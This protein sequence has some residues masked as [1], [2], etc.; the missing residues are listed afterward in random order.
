M[1]TTILSIEHSRRW[2]WSLTLDKISER[3]LQYK[4]IR[5]LWQPGRM[6]EPDLVD[7]F[8]LTM[9][10]NLDGIKC[11]KNKRKVVGRMGGF[12][13]NKDNPSYR[14]DAELAQVAAV[15]ATNGELFEIG[16][17]VNDSTFL[18]QNGTD[19]Q[20]FKPRLQRQQPYNNGS[21]PFVVG[22]VGNI[23]GAGMHYKGWKY[24]VQ[25]TLRLRPKIETKNFLF[26]HNQI[27]NNRMPE[28]FYHKIDC[29]VLPSLGEGCSNT[30][31]EALACGVPVLLTKVGFH[32]ER[33]DNG[34]NC[35]FIERDIDDIME[36]I[37]LLMNTPELRMK[38]A[39]EG[40]LFAENN[41]DINKIA[42]EYNRVFKHILNRSEI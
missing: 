30:I 23:L 8:D 22:F 20:L 7:Y 28:E 26:G 37:Q 36:K 3:L 39:F 11:I 32:G 25:A 19:L 33:L 12:F 9:I 40:R 10:Q 18:I 27:L 1:A 24:Y 17:R 35:L 21:R 16:K 41:H 42:F 5:I 14:Y 34:V 31:M 15:I 29:L 38:L 6:I 2:S 4:L 13:V